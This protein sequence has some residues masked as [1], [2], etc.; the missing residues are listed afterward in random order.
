MCT[1]TPLGRQLG[2]ERFGPATSQ[3]LKRVAADPIE[4]R[5]IYFSMD[6]RFR[7]REDEER[8]EQVRQDILFGNTD[9][10]EKRDD[11]RLASIIEVGITVGEVL[12][13][14]GWR[15]SER[16]SL[17]PSDAECCSDDAEVAATRHMAVLHDYRKT[18][19]Y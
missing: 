3:M 8:I 13:E 10:L 16:G 19:I 11:F 6:P 14:I 15:C 4:F 18:E 5:E 12:C 2:D 17:V 7:D 1:R 9:A